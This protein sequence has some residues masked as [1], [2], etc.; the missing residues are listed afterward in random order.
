MGMKTKVSICG[1]GWLGQPLAVHLAQRGMVVWGSRQDPQSASL[2]SEYGI[3]G[4]ALSLPADLTAATLSPRLRQFFDT[5][6]LVINVPPGRQ[7]GADIALINNVTL[8]ARY[9]RQNGCRRLIFISTT[10]VYGNATGSV[11]EATLPCPDTASGKAHY[12]LE[13][14]LQQEWGNDVV[15]LRLAG[16]IGP[17]RH[18]VKFLSGREGIANGSDRVNLIHQQDCIAA[19]SRIIECWP[20]D[21]VLHLSAHEHPT[22]KEYYCRMAK[23]LGL[24]VPQFLAS[25]DRNAKVVDATYTCEKLSLVLQYPTLMALKPDI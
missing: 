14:Q 13:Q 19:V 9:A 8:L 16:L 15:V 18:P 21:V 23:L 22:R 3:E 11:T 17:G 1:C 10:A 24:S 2:L 7:E 6:V 4:V 5:D 20:E 25:D 12:Q